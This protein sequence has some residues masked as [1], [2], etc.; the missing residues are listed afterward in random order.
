MYFVRPWIEA[1]G[2][3]CSMINIWEVTLNESR[4]DRGSQYNF[5][6]SI[7][8]FL[9]G[10]AGDMIPT[11]CQKISALR[12]GERFVALSPIQGPEHTIHSILS[13]TL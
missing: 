6:Q 13:S 1:N 7:I 2:I 12:S 4:G 5:G 10:L 11:A 3:P 8:C 9:I